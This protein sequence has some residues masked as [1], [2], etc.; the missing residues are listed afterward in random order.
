MLVDKTGKFLV[1]TNATKQ[2]ISIISCGI[3]FVSCDYFGR[4]RFAGAK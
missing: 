2:F 1:L 3:S 4:L